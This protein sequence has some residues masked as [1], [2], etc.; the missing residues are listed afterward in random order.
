MAEEANQGGGGQAPAVKSFGHLRALEIEDR[1]AWI[2]IP[3]LRPNARF[4]C[5]PATESNAGYF[6]ALLLDTDDMTRGVSSGRDPKRV[7]EDAR[8]RAKRIYAAHVIVGW[9]GIDYEDGT[10]AE[11]TP[12]NLTRMLDQM[13]GWMFDRLRQR[14]ELVETFLPSRSEREPKPAPADTDAI[15]KN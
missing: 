15:A 10:A 13:P 5:R 2:A 4:L 14:C 6:N 12:A 7:T 1:T 9:D 11:F 3:H 8:K